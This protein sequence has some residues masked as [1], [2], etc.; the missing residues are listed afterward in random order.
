MTDKGKAAAVEATLNALRK[1]QCGDLVARKE[2]KK[3]DSIFCFH[4]YKV[5]EVPL[6]H[7]DASSTK[8]VIRCQ[9]FEPIGG[10]GSKRFKMTNEIYDDDTYLHRKYSDMG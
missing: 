2:P 10:D 7:N 5:I 1:F 4:L 3:D 9:W 8:D 6:A